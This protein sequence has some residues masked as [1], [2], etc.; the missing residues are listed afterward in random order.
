MYETFR[1][2]PAV[3]VRIASLKGVLTCDEIGDRARLEGES[4][5]LRVVTRDRLSV[6]RAVR[7]LCHERDW[8]ELLD[9][10]AVGHILGRSEGGVALEASCAL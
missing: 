8:R 6:G 10:E 9:A 2:S 5:A 7:E 1:T 4:A 3:A